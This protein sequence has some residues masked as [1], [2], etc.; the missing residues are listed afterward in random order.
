LHDAGLLTMFVVAVVPLAPTEPVLTAL[1]VL[2]A[3]GHGGSPLVLIIV[4]GIGCSI[5]DH[6]LY[7]M[8]RFGG[9]RV[10]DWLGRRAAAAVPVNWL[11][12]NIDRW[13]APT[14]IAG[15]WLP[16][17]GTVGSILAG[18]LRWRLV[19][20]SPTSLTGCTLWSAYVVLLGY[21]GGTVAGNPL[22]GILL[23][24]GVAAV[25]GAGTR[26]VLR[27]GQRRSTLRL[28]PPPEAVDPAA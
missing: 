18:A 12:R 15:R 17:G 5:S 6:I 25:L 8:S 22:T 2:A 11:S 10:L 7:G 9:A 21:L 13:G 23:S 16:A 27:R 28:A 1:A 24:L 20:F 4:S 26:L 14:L 19:R 3:T